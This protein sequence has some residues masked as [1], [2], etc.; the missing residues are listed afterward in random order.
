ML[1][2]VVVYL[3]FVQV[4]TSVCAKLGLNNRNQLSK[5]KGIMASGRY[6][7]IIRNIKWIQ[8][9]VCMYSVRFM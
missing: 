2:T 5:R 7:T 3:F 8:E 1:Y 6:H 9:V 4:Y